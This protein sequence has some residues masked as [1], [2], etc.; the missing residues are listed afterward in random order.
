MKRII[1]YTLL[2]FMSCS[3]QKDKGINES[4]IDKSSISMDDDIIFDKKGKEPNQ[5][6]CNCEKD[7][8]VKITNIP[9]QLSTIATNSE[10]SELEKKQTTFRLPKAEKYHYVTLHFYESH[11]EINKLQI[12]DFNDESF[13]SIFLKYCCYKKRLPNVN[14]YQSYLVYNEDNEKTDWFLENET[15]D[16]LGFLMF[17]DTIL[18]QAIIFTIELVGDVA[19]G[20]WLPIERKVYIDKNFN[21]TVQDYEISIDW[22]NEDEKGNPLEK[23]YKGAKYLINILPTGNIKVIYP[24]WSMSIYE[25][26]KGDSRYVKIP[27]KEIIYASDGSIVSTKTLNAD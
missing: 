10:L 1:T 8:H 27:A 22:D 7:N 25:P 23:I 16:R 26:E 9:I 21:I 6:S 2:L 20:P 24:T 5:I 14:K 13:K 3:Y 17:Y 4:F 15:Y 18:N 11:D 19:G 12:E